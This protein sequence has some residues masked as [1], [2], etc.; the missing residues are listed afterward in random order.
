LPKLPR[1]NKD[2]RKKEFLEKLNE[3]GALAGHTFNNKN[4]ETTNPPR[5]LTPSVP[6][7]FELKITAYKNKISNSYQ[8]AGF[9]IEIREHLR[10]GTSKDTISKALDKHSPE[11]YQS[12]KGIFW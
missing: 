10:R 7:T 3:L 6:D 5:R 9:E 2:N 12:S 4:A 11:T 1:F 8:R